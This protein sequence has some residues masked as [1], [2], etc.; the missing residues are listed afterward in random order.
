[1]STAPH[2]HGVPTTDQLKRRTEQV[3]SE[4]RVAADNLAAMSDR[5]AE[6]VTELRQEN[7]DVDR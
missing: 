6:L 5:L 3:L 4:V 7:G 2:L 1:M